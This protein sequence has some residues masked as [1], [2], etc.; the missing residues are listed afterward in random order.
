[1]SLK[2]KVIYFVLLSFFSVFTLVACKSG[3]GTTDGREVAG[4]NGPTSETTTS[5]TSKRYNT[6]D[7]A[8]VTNIDTNKSTITFKS[9]DNG[10][11]YDLS[12]SGGT[13]FKSKNGSELLVSQ[14]D[15]GEIVDVY[16]VAGGQKLIQMEESSSV[17]RNESVTNFSINYEYGKMT[18]G[19]TQY[20]ID[21]N[22]VIKSEG[23]DISLEE[24]TELDELA[25]KGVGTNVKSI[26][27][28]RGHGY[29]RL[30]DETNFI[31]GL[32]ELSDKVITEIKDDM[33]LIAPEGTYNLTATKGG[34]GG[35]KEIT[36]KR[37]QE[38]TVSLS[39]FQ[40]AAK[41]YGA[42]KFNIG[43]DNAEALLYVDGNRTEYES[44]V[45]LP[46]GKHYIKITSNNYDDY[47]KYITVAALYTTINIDM[48][49]EQETTSTNPETTRPS[50]ETTT[51]SSGE[52]ET[53][54]ATQ[55]GGTS[56]ESSTSS[57]YMR[58]AGTYYNGVYVTTPVGASVYLD[59][60]LQGQA[61]ASF[62]KPSG[63]HYILLMKDGYKSK[64]YAVEFDNSTE[65][66]LLSYP[67]LETLSE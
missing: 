58:R 12:Y 50:E 62:N 26:L 64:V 5:E 33:V 51:T 27:V 2:K 8:I 67:E 23:K 54:T 56:S 53:T 32:I 65:D 60:T 46:Y 16:Y 24:L 55:S 42:V 36:V 31:G 3:G 45:D 6:T 22:V 19:N 66:I 43:P 49:G 18:I 34:A 35:T 28:K 38:L 10:S 44:V 13:R 11:T 30:V 61:P 39:E 17:F 29:V 1:M 59:G 4:I 40:A 25:V 57:N 63:K 15:L 7:F 14:F 20:I 48:S 41:R 52:D 9:I 37:D 21:K 47:E